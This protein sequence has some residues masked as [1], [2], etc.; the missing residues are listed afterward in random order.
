[1]R[2]L[3]VILPDRERCEAVVEELRSEGVPDNRIQVVAAAGQAPEGL[4]QATAWQKTELAHG[5]ELGTA[6]GGAG[7]LLGGLLAVTFPPAGLVLGGGAILASTAGGAGVGAV[8]SA[9]LGSH[10][11]NHDLDAFAEA[12]RAGRLLLMV[13]IPRTR[14]GRIRELILRHHPEAEIGVA[15]PKT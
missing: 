11:H 14:L 2:R 13:D 15:R 3:N 1:M 6:L 10:E 9:L 5:L 4:P 7:G 8:I 12:I